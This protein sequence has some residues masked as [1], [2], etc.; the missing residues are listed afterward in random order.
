MEGM[1]LEEAGLKAGDVITTI[2]GVEDRGMEMDYQ[3]YIEE[4]PLSG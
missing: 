4:H 2:N 1:P 3:E